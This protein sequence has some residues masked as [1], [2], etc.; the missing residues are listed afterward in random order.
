MLACDVLVSNTYL[1]MYGLYDMGVKSG[2]IKLIG[3]GRGSG[4]SWLVGVVNGIPDSM[5]CLTIFIVLHSTT[6]A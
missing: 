4:W 6:C 1:Y 5:L 2:K 3:Y